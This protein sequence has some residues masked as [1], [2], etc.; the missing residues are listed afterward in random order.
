[1]VPGAELESL[2]EIRVLHKATP[3]DAPFR[4]IKV[5][6][7][8]LSGILAIILGIGVIYLVDF[9]KSLSGSTDPDG[10]GSKALPPGTSNLSSGGRAYG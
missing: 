1:M 10:R 8:L 9:W 2:G 6:H 5:Y 4:P 7:V 3:Q